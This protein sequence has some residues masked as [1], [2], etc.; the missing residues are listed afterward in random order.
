MKHSDC[1]LS[2]LGNSWSIPV[3]AYLLLCLFRTL[4]MLPMMDLACLVEALDAGARASAVQLA[5]E[6]AFE[7]DHKSRGGAG[8]FGVASV[9]A[10]LGEG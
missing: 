1:R 9:R 8:R 7:T 5:V 6:T 10:D 3:V 2:L 4:G